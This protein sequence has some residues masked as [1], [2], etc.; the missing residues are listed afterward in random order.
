MTDS[1]RTFLNL[2]AQLTGGRGG[3]DS[4]I[5]NYVVAATC[6]SGWLAV[7]VARYREDHRP[8]ERLLIWGF[9]FALA[10]E[11]FMI[12][13]AGLQ[14]FK[15]VNPVA[16]HAVFPPLEHALHDLGLIT[17]AAGFLRYLVD[18]DAPARRYLRAGVAST[19]ACYLATFWWWAI[20]ITAHPA[21]KFGQTWCDWLFHINASVW[22]LIA[23]AYLWRR[24]LGWVRNAICAAQMAFFVD[25]VLKLPDMA[26]GEVQKACSRRFRA[27]SISA[28][29]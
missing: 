22:M 24:T 13:M 14:A 9:S 18:R 28:P 12:S 8:R 19:A 11:T 4:V 20:F 15:L 5:V 23:A 10:R 27:C 6:W 29:A 17:V 26:L 25:A 2:V 3:I 7:V 1:L 16:L 21:S